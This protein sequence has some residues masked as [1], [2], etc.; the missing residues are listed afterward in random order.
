VFAELENLVG[1][2]VAA[3]LIRQQAQ[4]RQDAAAVE[5]AADDAP[6]TRSASRW[7]PAHF[8][9]EKNCPIDSF[10]VPKHTPS[11]ANVRFVK[12]K[13]W[14]FSVSG[15]VEIDAESLIADEHLKPAEGTKLTE[16]R[17][18]QVP[19]ADTAVWWWD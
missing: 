14:M 3:A 8:L 16:T 2:S 15:G 11:L 13:F 18:R 5:A 1:L 9:D 19:P 6:A 17:T 7:R 10:A 12:D 4:M